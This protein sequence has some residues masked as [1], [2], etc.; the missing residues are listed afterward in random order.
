M[1]ARRF[2]LFVGSLV[3]FIDHDESEIFERRENRAA[4]AD[5]DP[6]AAGMNL[7]PFIVPLAFR[8]M[9]VQ[10][11]DHVRLRG[12][13]ALEALD[14]LRRERDFRDEHDRRLAA[15][16]RGADRLQIDF[17]FAAAGHAVEQNRRMRLGIFQRGFD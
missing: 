3:F 14:G 8:Q 6:R 5:H 2:L 11:R 10:D 15:R 4:R 9:A 7:V 13:A 17:R 12:E 1:I 16:E